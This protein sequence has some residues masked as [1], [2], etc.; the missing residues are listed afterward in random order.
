MIVDLS[1]PR[2][3]SLNDLI[4]PE[5]CSLSYPSV[6][7]AVEFILSLGRYTQLVKIDLKN[8]YWIL[9]IHPEDRVL[10]GISWEG[11]IYLDGCLPFGLRSAP[12]I[13][14]A[15]SDAIAW[16]LFSRGVRNVIHYLDDFLLFGAPFSNEAQSC[17]STTLSTF[18]ELGIP[19]SLP[20]LE[21]PHTS[22]TFLGILIDTAR[23]ELRLPL[24]K[25]HRIWGLVSDWRQKRSCR[26]SD[27]ESLLGHLSHAAVVVKP[28]RIFLRHMFSL[29]ARASSRHFYIH[30]DTVAKA[31]LAWWDCFLCDWHGA[32]FMVR[33][34][35]PAVVVHSDASGVFG[36]GAVCSNGYWTQLEWP[37]EWREVDISVK[38]LLPIVLAAAVWGHSWTRHRITFYSDNAAVVAVIQRRSAR[39]N[40][41]LH[42]LRCLYFYAAHFQFTYAARHIPGVNNV[43]ADALSR[44][45]M[46]TFLSLVPQGTLTQIPPSATAFL[47]HSRPDWG[48]RD[49]IRLFKTSL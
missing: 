48:S 16:V 28:G 20:K 47:L 31:D 39:D 10:L 36:C 19:V 18:D 17:L 4:P 2:G 49:W 5:A 3:H 35:W 8:A 27:L 21:G 37:P 40:H 43:A 24:D 42:L 11:H 7:D 23:M 13:F 44:N 1:H 9:P 22:V 33:A 30:L 32:S 26:R 12:K 38:E 14:T 25:L 29:L 45:H 15:F 41:L 6:D 34:D 46:S